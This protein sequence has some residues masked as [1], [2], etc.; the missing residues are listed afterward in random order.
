MVQNKLHFAEFW[1]P[2]ALFLYAE[3]C[4]HLWQFTFLFF[5]YHSEQ[6]ARLTN[7]F[8]KQSKRVPL[9]KRNCCNSFSLQKWNLVEGIW[10]ISWVLPPYPRITL[11]EIKKA[12]FK[13]LFVLFNIIIWVIA[14]HKTGEVV[15][16]LFAVHS[17]LGTSLHL[18]LL[19]MGISEF[20]FLHGQQWK[21]IPATRSSLYHQLNIF[22]F[23][24]YE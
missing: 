20:S 22:T 23:P 15:F 17:V 11:T 19:D 6:T 3:K 7:N 1:K 18:Q 5:C 4:T 12:I 16:S 8:L 2:L 10:A 14:L 24:Q 21:P 13:N 9:S